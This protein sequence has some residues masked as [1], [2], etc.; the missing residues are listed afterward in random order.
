MKHPREPNAHRYAVDER[1]VMPETGFEV[2]DGEVLYVPPADPPHATRH[3]K[4]CAL[5]EMFAAPGFIA[6]CEMLTRTSAKSDFAPDGSLY[7]AAPD[8][9]TGGRQLEHLAFEVVSTQSLGNAAKKAS[10]LVGRGVRR[11]FAIDVERQRALEWSRKTAS[12]EILPHSAVIED[13][14]LALPLR[15]HDLVGAAQVDDAVAQAL[16][17]KRNPVLVEALA[18]AQ[19][20]GEQ[21][22]FQQGKLE[23]ERVAKAEALLAIFRARALPI[24]AEA[25]ETI[26]TAEVARLDRWL[27]EA[28]TCE[29]VSRLLVGDSPAARKSR[30]RRAKRSS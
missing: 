19:A 28:V 1:L 30:P 21:R 4:L 7:P 26:R 15:V 25:E 2:V 14:A 27:V 18:K 12:W 10:G 17:A 20:L 22:G 9:E 23:G 3:S 11:V 8:P 24:V 5:L 6:A 16:L 13:V 29:N